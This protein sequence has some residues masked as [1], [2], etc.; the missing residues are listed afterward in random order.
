MLAR[1]SR[2]QVGVQAG[3][4]R[5]GF[6]KGIALFFCSALLHITTNNNDKAVSLSSYDM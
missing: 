6:G 3:I 1:I 2:V 4:H 5:K